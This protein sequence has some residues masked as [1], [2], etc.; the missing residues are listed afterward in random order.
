MSFVMMVVSLALAQPAAQKKEISLSSVPIGDMPLKYRLLPTLKDQKPGNAAYNYQ[1]AHSPEYFSALQRS[2]D[3]SKIGDW[4]ELPDA[5][6]AK[7]DLTAFRHQGILKE[8]QFAA[9]LE[10]CDWQLV[11]RLR[12][13]GIMLML[14][15]HSS[16]R[17]FS[18]ILAMDARRAILDNKFAEADR[19][20]ETGFSLARHIG[21]SPTFISGLVG[22]AIAAQQLAVVERWIGA[23][24]SPNLYWSLADLP[25]PFIDTR[26]AFQAEPIF[27]DQMFPEIRHALENPSAPPIPMATLTAC[28]KNLR[29]IEATAKES[30][31]DVMAGAFIVLRDHTAARTHFLKA[32]WTEKQ[33]DGLSGMQLVLMLNV[34]NCDRLYQQMQAWQS[35]PWHIARPAFKKFVEELRESKAKQTPGT[36]LSGMLMPALDRIILARV[37]VDRRIAALQTIEAIRQFGKLPANLE[38]IENVPIPPDPATGKAFPYRTEGN[39]GY[40]TVPRLEGSNDGDIEYVLRFR[41]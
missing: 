21:Q 11:H 30:I 39:T 18:Q 10:S 4:L 5:E 35:Q 28:M 9:R 38:A 2:P 6:F 16:F 26:L 14:P 34:E 24:G 8:L 29:V 33:V 32:G 15:D 40:L 20:L 7:L 12:T 27:I 13:D 22:M 19:S 1:R 37:R 31:A 3:F 17:Q 41:K 25:R 36:F 23:D